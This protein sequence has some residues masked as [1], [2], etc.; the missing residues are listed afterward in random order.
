MQVSIHTAAASRFCRF[1][2]FSYH[3]GKPR[4][5]L[6]A[7]TQIR[8]GCGRSSVAP[9]SA[10]VMP[11]ENPLFERATSDSHYVLLCDFRG[12]V[13]KES[14]EM[15][16]LIGNS[17]VGCFVGV[18]MTPAL[19]ELHRRVFFP[20]YQRSRGR[21]RAQFEEDI[22]QHSLRNSTIVDAMGQSLKACLEVELHKR[23]FRVVIKS[24]SAATHNFNNQEVLAT[25]LGLGNVENRSVVRCM[26]LLVVD[27]VHS[28]EFLEEHGPL[29]SYQRHARIQS[30][31]RRLINGVYRPLVKLYECVGDSLFFVSYNSKSELICVTLARFA[32]DLLTAVQREDDHL[33]AAMTYGDVLAAVM[34]RQVRFFGAPVTKACRLQTYV[35]PSRGTGHFDDVAVCEDFYCSLRAELSHLPPSVAGAWDAALDTRLQRAELKGFGE[36]VCFRII[37]MSSIRTDAESGALPEASDFVG[38]EDLSR[39][40]EEK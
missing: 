12:R 26:A 31:A 37:D 16:T 32:L 4:Q 20:A 39:R 24:V 15:T 35:S 21:A 28:T 19:A 17:I 29:A 22:F 10:G 2:T 18:I 36:S 30:I 23:G 38:E 1:Q 11:I 8:M 25:R 14:S 6:S 3:D 34:D 13:S 33:R 40:L 27:I 7:Y 5:L 9:L